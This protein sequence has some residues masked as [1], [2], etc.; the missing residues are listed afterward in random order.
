[1]VVDLRTVHSQLP[2]SI[3][4][5]FLMG[6]DNDKVI[7]ARQKFLAEYG[8]SSEDGPPLVRLNLDGGKDPFTLVGGG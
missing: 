8:L 1:M 5:F 6:S 2:D 3:E 7:D 4:A